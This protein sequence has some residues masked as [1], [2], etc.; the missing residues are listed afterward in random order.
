MSRGNQECEFFGADPIATAERLEALAADLRRLATGRSPS[1]AELATAPTLRHWGVISRSAM[2]L[3]G[4]VEGHPRIGDDRRVV[5]SELYA[6]DAEGQWART[7]NRYYRLI[8]RNQEN[9]ND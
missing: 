4:N 9:S 6:L 1:P 2:A 5:S 8:T 3:I 7:M